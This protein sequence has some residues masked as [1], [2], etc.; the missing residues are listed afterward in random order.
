[1]VG[2]GASVG[3]DD[4]LHRPQSGRPLPLRPQPSALMDPS[5]LLESMGNIMRLL[6]GLP[7]GLHF[8]KLVSL[9]PRETDIR[10]M[11]ELVARRSDTLGHPN[12]TGYPLSMFVLGLA[13]EL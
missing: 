3:D 12:V 9:R 2:C 1:M 4:D 6:V 13:L 10:W 7:S 5:S 8:R 11:M